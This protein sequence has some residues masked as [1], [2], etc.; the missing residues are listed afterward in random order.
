MN[1]NLFL[2]PVIG[3]VIGY[4]TNDIAIKMLFHPRKTLYIGKWRVPS[5]PGL[6]PKEKDR[7]ARSVGN[8]VSTQLLSSDVISVTLT[9]DEMIGKI[10]GPLKI[11]LKGTKI[12]IQLLRKL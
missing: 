10:R 9:S 8:V 7:V 1:I 6:I 12:M 3:A 5:T 11:L 4:I 2:A